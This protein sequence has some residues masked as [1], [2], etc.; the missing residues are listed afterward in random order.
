MVPPEEMSFEPG[1]RLKPLKF[2][3]F[4]I[5]II[6]PRSDEFTSLVIKSTYNGL[7]FSALAKSDRLYSISDASCSVI[8]A[9]A[10]EAGALWDALKSSSLDKSSE[11]FLVR[12]L[13]RALSF[14]LICV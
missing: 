4:I 11:S 13:A 5:V 9:G 6:P 10:A 3:G 8:I 1:A 2:K 7:S 12:D 14:S